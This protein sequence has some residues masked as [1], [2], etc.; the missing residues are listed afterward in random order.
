VPLGVRYLPFSEYC[1]KVIDAFLRLDIVQ[2]DG[3][4]DVVEPLKNS[5]V[6]RCSSFSYTSFYQSDIQAYEFWSDPTGDLAPL[7]H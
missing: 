7:S 5:L 6:L 3:A 4:H 2:H 1:W